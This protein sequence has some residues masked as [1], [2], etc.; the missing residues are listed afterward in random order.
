MNCFNCKSR[1][2]YEVY[3]EYR[4]EDNPAYKGIQFHDVHLKC[5]DCGFTYNCVGANEIRES[6]SINSSVLPI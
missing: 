2:F 1:K 6:K 5:T 3:N 4:T